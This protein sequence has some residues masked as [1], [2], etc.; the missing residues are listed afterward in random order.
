MKNDLVVDDDDD[1]GVN[2][3]NLRK[4]WLL[5]VKVRT[6]WQWLLTANHK[7]TSDST[8]KRRGSAFGSSSSSVAL[9]PKEA[10]PCTKKKWERA[11][12]CVLD[13]T[14]C[15]LESSSSERRPVTMRVNHG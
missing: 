15:T 9:F 2:G 5:T 11:V 12:S 13:L 14:R 7:S 8:K 6:N 1:G 3:K 10:L 4:T